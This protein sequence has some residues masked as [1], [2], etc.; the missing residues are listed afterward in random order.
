MRNLS[1]S[2]TGKTAKAPVCPGPATNQLHFSGFSSSR[3]NPVS[4]EILRK[5]KSEFCIPPVKKDE[6][7]TIPHCSWNFK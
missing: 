3:R 1:N 7:W 6:P 5:E 2:G 4:T